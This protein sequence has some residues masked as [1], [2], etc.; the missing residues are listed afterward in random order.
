LLERNNQEFKT[1]R[2]IDALNA[3]NEQD[4]LPSILEEY[5]LKVEQESTLGTRG[6]ITLENTLKP[7]I[8][9]R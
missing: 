3:Q 8:L 2:G 7:E 9:I 1:L 6:L 5:D 4:K